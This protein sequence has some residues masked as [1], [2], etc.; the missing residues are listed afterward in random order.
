MFKPF[1]LLRQFQDRKSSSKNILCG[2]DDDK[3]FYKAAM[4]FVFD[5]FESFEVRKNIR[6]PKKE[7]DDGVVLIFDDGRIA[8][9]KTQSNQLTDGEFE[10]VLRVCYFLQDTYGGSIE[11]YVFCRPEVEIR[12]YGR[13][14]RDGIALILSTLRDFDGDA[15]VC[16]LENKRRNQEKFIFQDYVCRILLPFMG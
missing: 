3:I 10:S 9:F 14:E 8:Y 12:S 13:I 2:G 16:M 6:I 1:R 5:E 15:V 11:A 4:A 7:D